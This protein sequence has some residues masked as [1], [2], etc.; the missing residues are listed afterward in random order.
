MTENFRPI[1]FSLL[2]MAILI[3]GCSNVE[4][5]IYS[6]GEEFV[7]AGS[8]VIYIDTLSVATSTILLDSIETNNT[9]QILVGNLLD[10]ETG[11]VTVSSYLNFQPK[12]GDINALKEGY[13]FDS[14]VFV[15]N[16]SGYWYGDTTLKHD[17]FIHQLTEPIEKE[18]DD[19][20]YNLTSFSFQNEP[21]AHLEW[22][23]K[24]VE[25]QKLKMRMNDDLGKDLFRMLLEGSD[26]ISNSI[27]FENKYPGFI[28]APGKETASVIGF[29]CNSS[30]STSDSTTAILQLYYHN[31]DKRID[32]QEDELLSVDFVVGD[33]SDQFNHFEVNRGETPLE[34]IVENT[35]GVS[36]AETSNVT[37]I[38]GGNPLLTLLQFPTIDQLL[39]LGANSTLLSAQLK[40]A[41][42]TGSFDDLNYLPD[43]L[44]V[45]VVNKKYRVTSQMTD[46]AGE[47]VIGTPVIDEEFNENNYYLFDITNYLYADLDDEVPSKEWIALGLPLNEIQG[48]VN[49]LCI[50]DHNHPQNKI[51][52]LV[53]YIVY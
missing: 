49:R 23:P 17:I 12:S 36:S 18:E 4:E 31:P 20:I 32:D 21:V 48:S 53:H 13:V 6:V 11:T 3:G 8:R 50:G 2:F 22:F 43:S 5:S 47:Y 51:E 33:V 1:I 30:S 39:Y 25:A 45:Y 26:T 7:E 24:P 14:L 42:V 15:M 29:K 9:E 44:C 41:P 28:V 46:L 16:Y 37:Y 40:V 19:N 38:Q 34:N 27:L 52:L 10:V 35:R